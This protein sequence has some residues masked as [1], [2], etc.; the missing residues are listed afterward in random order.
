MKLVDT[1][2]VSYAMSRNQLMNPDE[3]TM[4]SICA[5]ELLL[6]Q[7]ESCREN[8]Y[9]IPL[10]QAL[11]DGGVNPSI[12][13]KLMN[14]RPFAHRQRAMRRRT[15]KLVLEFGKDFPRVIEYSHLAIAEAINAKRF[16]LL[17][18]CIRNLPKERRRVALRRLDF[19][20]LS[21]IQCMPLTV[22]I[23]DL[24]LALFDAFSQNYALK[25]RFRNSLN[26]ILSVAV[27]AHNNISLETDDRL[28]RDFMS[29]PAQEIVH[30]A[31]SKSG[32]R[33]DAR[34]SLESKGYINR[35]WRVM[36]TR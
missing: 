32:E 36:R 26:D 28:L 29:G 33:R 16:A 34:P 12:Y 35:G 3:K 14:G 17:A 24:A 19:L 25:A 7:G 9:Y 27:A 31:E 6:V 23:A 13:L 21:G 2:I 18:G 4:S 10:L 5:Q 22:D 8:Q 1:Q 15:D 30:R 20:A 11:P